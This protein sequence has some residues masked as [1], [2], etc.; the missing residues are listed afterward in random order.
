MAQ[1]QATTAM[2][3]TER[4]VFEIFINGTMDAVWRQ[5]TKTDEPQE[6]FFN[7]WMDTTTLGPGA[8]IRMRSKSK[9]TTGV[10]GEV[11][12][13][14]PP[15]RF[16]HTFRFTHLDDPECTVIYD[17]TEK[18]GGVLFR[19]TLENLPV[20][21]KTAKQMNQGGPMITKTLKNMVENG[22]P[23]LGV[24]MLFKLFGALEITAPK[25]CASENWPL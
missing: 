13:W 18:D 22:R 15:R 7:N 11:V 20:G 16:A 9:K 14:D 1:A 2:A 5:I 24:R 21:A 25:K 8:P 19:M 6:T 17:L 23:S 10:V 3:Q 4:A 12:E